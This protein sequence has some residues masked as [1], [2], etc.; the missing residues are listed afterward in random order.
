MSCVLA[1]DAPKMMS[2]SPKPAAPRGALMVAQSNAGAHRLGNQSAP[3]SAKP[4]HPLKAI[5]RI[6]MTAVAKIGTYTL[7]ILQHVPC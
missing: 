5:L 4:G 6:A 2:G 1:K 7:S 3:P